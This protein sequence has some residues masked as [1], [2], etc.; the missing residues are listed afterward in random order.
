MNDAIPQVRI[1]ELTGAQLV[2]LHNRIVELFL[3]GKPVARFESATAG[4]RRVGQLI[5]RAYPGTYVGDDGVAFLPRGVE[6]RH[7]T[8]E[9]VD[10][11]NLP[12]AVETPPVAIDEPVTVRPADPGPTFTTEE[13]TVTETP[14][15]ATKPGRRRNFADT[16]TISILASENPKR[17]GS[18]AHTRFALY[19]S[20]MTVAE[21]VKVGGKPVDLAWDVKHGFIA[22]A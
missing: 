11:R 22:V 15:T 8:L 2:K 19:R 7:D 1:A 4:K 14:K 10:S 16:A 17:A 20:G 12:V 9:F 3:I 5:S 18:Q 6:F 21:F 13:P